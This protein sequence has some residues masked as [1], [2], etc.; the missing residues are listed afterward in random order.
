[1]IKSFI[2]LTKIY[3]LLLSLLISA[4][5][6]SCDQPAAEAKI[7][8]NDLHEINIKVNG[9]NIE[10][11]GIINLGTLYGGALGDEITVRIENLKR[12]V[13]KLTGDPLVMLS[14]ND[15]GAFQVDE[16]IL[17]NS[18][19][20]GSFTL[21]K[22]KIVSTVVGQK[23]LTVTI[24]NNDIDENK[25][26]FTINVYSD[27]CGLIVS[28]NDLLYYNDD[29]FTFDNTVA[30]YNTDVVLTLNNSH[31]DRSIIIGSIL[32]SG[33]DK[34]HFSIVENCAGF[35]KP[36]ESTAIKLRFNPFSEGEKNAEIIISSNDVNFS[37]YKIKLRGTGIYRHGSIQVSVNELENNDIIPIYGY[38]NYENVDVNSEKTVNFKIK[39]IQEGV[40]HLTGDPK[41]VIGGNNSVN[42]LITKQ[43]ETDELFFNE[44]AVFSVKFSPSG[45]GDKSCIITILSDDLVTP[46]FNFYLCGHG[47]PVYPNMVIDQVEYLGNIRIGYD[48]ELNFR[49]RNTGLAD[50]VLSGNPII[51][52]IS[53]NLNICIELFPDQIIPPGFFSDFKISVYGYYGSGNAEVRIPNNDINKNPYIFY[54]HKEYSSD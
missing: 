38:F 48:E 30:G 1:M 49:I 3:F 36:H 17:T 15:A 19:K 24:E 46:V 21:F 23:S 13:L 6:I 16:T 29:L 12:G 32:L 27:I 37:I 28:N 41:V 18:I 10:S 47:N 50:L 25:Y 9:E 20:G 7:S 33:L 11:E 2:Y 26:T 39:N 34:S 4:C 53:S 44:T 54:I 43:P 35:I 42:F 14:G 22:L 45:E 5:I 8:E 40:L 51:Q 31:S 52:I